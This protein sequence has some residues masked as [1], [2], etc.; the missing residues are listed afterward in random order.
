MMADPYPKCNT[1]S[2]R[3]EKSDYYRPT[4]AGVMTLNEVLNKASESTTG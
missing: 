2:P 3:V 1:E 4:F